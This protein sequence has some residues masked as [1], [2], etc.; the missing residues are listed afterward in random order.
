MFIASSPLSDSAIFCTLPL[1]EGQKVSIGIR[2]KNVLP[3]AQTPYRNNLLTACINI[4]EHLG[5]AAIIYVTLDG[6][7]SLFAIKL[8]PDTSDLF[9][10]VNLRIQSRR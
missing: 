5:D 2:A 7:E 10:G 1:T 4:V 9:P 8:P 6:E 3:T